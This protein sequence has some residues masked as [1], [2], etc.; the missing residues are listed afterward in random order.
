M[1]YTLTLTN[2]TTL[3]TVNDGSLD[4]TTDLTFVGKNY[5]GYG[6]ILNQ[7][8]LSLLENF[9]GKVSPSTPITGELWYDTGTTKLRV[10]NSTRFK[11]VATLDSGNT[12]P[13]DLGTGDLFWNQSEGKLYLYDGASFVAIGPQVSGLAATNTVQYANVYDTNN[14]THNILEHNLQNQNGTLVPIAIET[15]DPT[16]FTLNSVNP[17]TGYTILKQGITLYGADS[18]TGVSSSD[19]NTGYIMWGSAAHALRLGNYDASTYLL[20][21]LNSTTATIYTD[22]VI[23]SPTNIFNLGNLTQLKNE[24]GATNIINV[25]SAGNSEISLKIYFGSGYADVANF[26]LSK[27]NSLAILPTNYPGVTSDIGS[28]T[29]KFMNIYSTSSYAV[30]SYSTTTYVQNIQTMFPVTSGFSQS[31][32]TQDNPFDFVYASEVV[33]ESLQTNSFV[34]PTYATT[35][36]RDA[37]IPSPQAG[38]MVFITGTSSFMGY[39]GTAWKTLT[40]S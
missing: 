11:P 14:Y 3:T 32:G 35:A 23:S 19:G 38:T 31:I 22:L 16:G 7:D 13:T 29:Q 27:S 8:L 37:A 5:S 34:L 18:L 9:A 40:T 33:T 6:A 26:G 24:S 10:Y 17:I 15:V 21:G 4:T 20:N 2:G 1:S 25:N 12:Y 36:D 39:N 30:N 28:P